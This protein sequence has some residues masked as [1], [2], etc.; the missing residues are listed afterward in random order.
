MTRAAQAALTMAGM[1]TPDITYTPDIPS[2]AVSLLD[3]NSF[4]NV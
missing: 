4:E 3:Y 1:E 2:D